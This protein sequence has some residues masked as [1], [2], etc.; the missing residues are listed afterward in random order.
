MTLR[1]LFIW[2]V[3]RANIEFAPT[4]SCDYDGS[5]DFLF[6]IDASGSLSEEE[7]ARDA[8]CGREV[9]DFNSDLWTPPD[10]SLTVKENLQAR[11]IS[12]PSVP[13]NCADE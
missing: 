9:Y 11:G 8:R 2:V 1:Q 7:T 10:A 12:V 6:D 3:I 5:G 13:L 4:A